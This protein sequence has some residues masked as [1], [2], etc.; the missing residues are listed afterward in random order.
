MGTRCLIRIFDEDGKPITTIYTQGDGYPDG[1]PLFIMQYISKRRFRN[2]IQDTWMDIN[3]MD[4]L[5]AHIVVLLKMYFLAPSIRSFSKPVDEFEIPA[6][7]VYIM[8]ADIKNVGEEYEY[9]IKPIVKKKEPFIEYKGLIVEAYVVNGGKLKRF[10]KGTPLKYVEL[11]SDRDK[12]E[13]IV[14]EVLA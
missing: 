4:D 3:G 5:A 13:K 10:F 1:A 7:F 2:G 11:F 12:A 6:G 8:P 9:H 14:E